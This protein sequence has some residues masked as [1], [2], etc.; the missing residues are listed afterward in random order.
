MYMYDHVH[1]RSSP[2]PP[3]LPP[4]HIRHF[5]PHHLPLNLPL[6]TSHPHPSPLTTSPPPTGVWML[7]GYVS[8]W[9]ECTSMSTATVAHSPLQHPPPPTPTTPHTSCGSWKLMNV[10][11]SCEEPSNSK[12]QLFLSYRCTLFVV[13]R[14]IHSKIR[15]WLVYI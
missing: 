11:Y 9:S 6:T 15:Y 5:F 4:C 13:T 14:C 12:L 2:P 10:A 8:L 7:P 1:S 3:S